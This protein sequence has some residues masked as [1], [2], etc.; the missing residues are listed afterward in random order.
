MSPQGLLNSGRNDLWKYSRTSNSW[1]RVDHDIYLGNYGTA[2]VASTDN[3]PGPR[4]RAVSWIDE[5]GNSWVFGGNRGDGSTAS[6]YDYLDLWKYNPAANAWTW[7]S[8]SN[9][10]GTPGEYGEIGVSSAD[11]FPGA[12]EGA[13]GWIDSHDHLWLF[14]GVGGGNLGANAG[15]EFNDLWEFDPVA[16]VWTWMSGSAGFNQ[17]GNYGTKGVTSTGNL[18]PS[19]DG[20]VSW[21]DGS[22]NLWLF[23]GEFR[24]SYFN[25]LWKYNPEDNTWTWVSGSEKVDVAGEY[26]S[27]GVPSTD[28][29]PGARM[30][31]VSWVDSSG[32]LW[33]FGGDGLSAMKE[34]CAYILTGPGPGSGCVASQIH[35][36]YQDIWKFNP[37]SN[38]WTWVNGSNSPAVAY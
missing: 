6:T 18:P 32:D 35:L 34:S 22:G 5:G 1:T 17:I 33:L 26:G 14:G 29:S 28:N 12:R 21:I 8:G 7:V 37:K 31:A 30:G 36:I 15:G 2:G 24:G 19:R 3:I 38:T 10:I 25:D 9:K 11:T 13:V 4:E 20:A 27:K 23:G 16:N